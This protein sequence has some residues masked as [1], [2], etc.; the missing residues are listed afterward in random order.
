M[1]KPLDDAQKVSHALLKK[2]LLLGLDGDDVEITAEE[3][4]NIEREALKVLESK[5]A[6]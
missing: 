5:K 2:E 4:D 6:L 3:W 1:L